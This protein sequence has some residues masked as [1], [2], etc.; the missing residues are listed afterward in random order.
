LGA[1]KGQIDW[2]E[3]KWPRPSQRVD[4]ITKPTMN[5]YMAVTEGEGSAK[6]G[7]PKK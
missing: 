2:V 7:S 3:I 4:R 6:E 5:R 1:G